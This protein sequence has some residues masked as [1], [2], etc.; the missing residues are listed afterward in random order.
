MDSLKIEEVIPYVGVDH[1]RFG[2]TPSEVTQVW[3]YLHSRSVNFINQYVEYRG[4]VSTTYS[5]ENQFIEI[6]L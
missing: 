1:V 6:G 2:M 5:S 3:G 4:S